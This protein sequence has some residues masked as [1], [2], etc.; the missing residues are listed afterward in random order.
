MEFPTL[1]YKNGGK[2]QR[3]G[4]TYST[5]PAKDQEQLSSLMQ[6]GWFP[7]LPEAVDGQLL[8]PTV[9]RE[10][11]QP[12]VSGSITA[13]QARAAIQAVSGPTREQMEAKAKELGIKV[14]WNL[15][16]ETLRKRIEDKLAEA[17]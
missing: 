10:L 6:D 4:G 9:S 14:R 13:D 12:L 2:Y 16:D 8:E 1:V 3:S 7:S 15:G 11:K 17:E 5:A